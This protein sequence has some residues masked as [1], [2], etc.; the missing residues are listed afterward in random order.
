[1]I[2]D[3]DSRNWQEESRYSSR[4]SAYLYAPMVNFNEM[5]EVGDTPP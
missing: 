2:T 4:G 1:M 5:A 3:R